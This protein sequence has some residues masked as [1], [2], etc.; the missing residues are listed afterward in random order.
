M[1]RSLDDTLTDQ[2][3]E[4][5]PKRQRIEENTHLGWQIFCCNNMDRRLPRL[6]EIKKEL[7]YHRSFL[8]SL[9]LVNPLY[10][11]YPLYRYSHPQ[12][13]HIEMIIKLEMEQ[14]VI[15]EV[16]KLDPPTEIHLVCK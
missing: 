13:D 5:S 4:R 11:H 12:I 16:A 3:V 15:R 1:K 6:S 9:F 10:K 8:P 14:K 2:K 7:L